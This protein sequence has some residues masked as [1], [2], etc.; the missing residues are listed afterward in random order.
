MTTL[1]LTAAYVRALGDLHDTAA[2]EIGD[3][4][5]SVQ[6]VG[7]NMSKTHGLICAVTNAA[8]KAAEAARIDAGTKTRQVSEEL[9]DKL[10]HAADAYDA[11]DAAEERKLQDQMQPGN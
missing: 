6:L 4:V 2:G 9:A 3:A 5:G 10:R 8:V 7:E 11:T 1:K